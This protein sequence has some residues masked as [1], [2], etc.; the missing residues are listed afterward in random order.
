MFMNYGEDKILLSN[1]PTLVKKHGEVVAENVQKILPP[2]IGLRFPKVQPS[3]FSLIFYTGEIQVI[4][5]GKWKQYKLTP[6][7]ETES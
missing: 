1:S 5:T 4:Y 3:K 6:V 7:L 2:S